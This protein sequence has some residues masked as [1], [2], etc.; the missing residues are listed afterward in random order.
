[1]ARQ[2]D[3]GARCNAELDARALARLAR[4]DDGAERVLAR[5]YAVGALSARGRHRVVRVA[6]TIADLEAAHH[7]AES[8]VL[9]ALSLRQRG[10]AE[11]AIAA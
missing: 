5:A 1:M 4:L 6:R 8:H 11:E 3:T 7:V 2:G 10:A 9:T